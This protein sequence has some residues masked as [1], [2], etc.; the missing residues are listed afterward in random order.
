[1][2]SLQLHHSLTNFYELAEF[3]QPYLSE[4][5]QFFWPPTTNPD[6]FR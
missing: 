5:P 1:M 4:D 6:L 3:P 2:E